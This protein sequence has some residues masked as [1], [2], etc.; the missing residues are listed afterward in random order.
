MKLFFANAF[1]VLYL[2]V[3]GLGIVSHTVG[4]GPNAHP[5][6]YFVV[7]DMF[8]GWTSFGTK[9]HVIGE[10]KSGDFYALTPAPWGELK[11]YGYA[12]RRHYDAAG[13]HSPRFGLNVL[14][15]T[16]H[17][18]I[19]KIYVIEESWAKKYDL[20]DR[21]W[22][23][24]YDAPKEIQ[25]Y[26][27]VLHVFTPSG[28]IIMSNPSWLEQQMSLALTNNPRLVREYRQSHPVYALTP[29]RRSASEVAPLDVRESALEM[30]AKAALGN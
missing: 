26:Y 13:N 1:I 19:A 2:A 25:A 23:L 16:E 7:W 15:Y 14:R 5:M 9:I 17:E 10:G 30:S 12:P 18:E 22:K 28:E 3:M 8:C 29:N 11:P 27:N 24:Q 4:T 20:D 6:M 21:I